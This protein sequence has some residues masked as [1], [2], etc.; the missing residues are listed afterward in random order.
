[1]NPIRS[2]A[3][4]RQ[5]E[6]FLAAYPAYGSTSAID[7]LR[8]EEFAR[9][10]ADRHVYLDYTGGGLYAESQVRR[11]AELLLSGVFGNPHSS[12]PTSSKADELVHEC[13]YHV[14]EFFSASPEEYTVVFTG[15][16]SHALKLVG[17]AYPFDRDST[18]LLTFDNH[19]SVN[20]I[21][22]F[23]RAHG[24]ATVYVPVAPPEMRVDEQVI[25][26]SLR[27]AN[28]AAH[29]LFAF[30]AQSNFSGVHHPL[31]WL[32]QAQAAGWDVLLDAAAFVPT[33]RLDLSR[34]HP[35]FVALSFYKMFGY[36]TGVGALIARRR[37]LEKL[38]RPWFA[39]G[40]IAAASVR[41]DRYYPA[42][43]AAAF[44]EG[45]VNYLTIPAVEDG[46]RLLE[47]VGLDVVHER[48]ACLTGWLL[49]ALGALRHDNGE[50]LVRFYGPATRRGRGGTIALNLCD[51]DGRPIDHRVVG[52]RAARD[53][54]SLRTGSF[55]NPG[56]GE[57]ALGLSKEELEDC[58]RRSGDWM[59]ADDF[60]RCIDGKSSGAVRVSFGLV[61]NF[62]DAQA[63]VEFATRFLEWS[64]DP[65]D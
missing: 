33:N 38:H 36:P 54:I 19:N 17:E 25:A 11:H 46:L 47:R 39:G 43:G 22:E 29:N 12:N 59:R 23:A 60:R 41:A 1:M 45:T 64:N 27:P 26:G 7:E 56:A 50:P 30:P 49:D 28:P 8:K 3:G 6:A 21:R 15:N 44:E 57:A 2:E 40:T 16:A 58:F 61:S 35:D 9:L 63:M 62:A 55:C 37:A 42:P 51:R 20:G 13:R 4:E 18:F 48:V 10:D 32:D 53:H 52:R 65:Q 5:L 24:A 31:D 34:W 14:L